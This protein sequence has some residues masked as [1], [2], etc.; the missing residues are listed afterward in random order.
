RQ[1]TP[2]VPRPLSFGEPL[3]GRADVHR[4]RGDHGYGE[5]HR[6]HDHD[7][8]DDQARL[9]RRRM[10]ERGSERLEIQNAKFKMQNGNAKCREQGSACILHFAFCILNYSITISTA[11][12]STDIPSTTFTALT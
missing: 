10:A 3:Q 5:N 2:E 6:A 4:H 7:A 8:A 12:P 1:G 9:L 11:P